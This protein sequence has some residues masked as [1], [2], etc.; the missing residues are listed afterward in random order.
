MDADAA[1][2]TLAAA[3]P[4]LILGEAG[5]SKLVARETP[6]WFKDQ[7]SG[8]WLGRFPAGPQ[9]WL[10]ALLEVAAAA[11]LV[12]GIATGETL[13]GGTIHLVG[14]G[15]LLA[16]AVFTMLSFGLRVAA[17]FAGSASGYFYAALTLGLYAF[18]TT[19]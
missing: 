10:I 5:L 12:A 6:D 14:W 18:V 19:I 11:L 3:L 17:D 1:F 4:M 15:L 8:T 2:R 16:A 9:W 13:A 7:F